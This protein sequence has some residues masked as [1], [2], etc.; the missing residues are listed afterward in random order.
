MSG[1]DSSAINA[2]DAVYK[3]KTTEARNSRRNVKEHSLNIGDHVLCKQNKREKWTTRYEL[4]IYEIVKIV[5]SQIQARRLRDRY[6][7][8]QEASWWKAANE[9][10]I[11]EGIDKQDAVMRQPL[12]QC[13]QAQVDN[14]DNREPTDSVPDAP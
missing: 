7:L 11:G 2:R 4:A 3:Q 5:E 1:D 9:I 14:D 13:E 6:R 8:C 12:M 10:E